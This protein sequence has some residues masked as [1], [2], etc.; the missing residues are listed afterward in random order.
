MT[1]V[2]P[3]DP[4]YDGFRVENIWLFTVIDKDDDQ[5]GIASFRARGVQWPLIASD[6]TRRDDYM[7][8][9]KQIAAES[10]TEV[11]VSRMSVRTEEARISPDGEVTYTKE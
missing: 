2:P 7:K 1:H 9:A 10:E 8:I 6:P 5:E 4:R 3:G 11:I